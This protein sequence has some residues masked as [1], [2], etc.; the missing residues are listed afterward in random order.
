M[1]AAVLV[2]QAVLQNLA[3]IILVVVSLT[4]SLAHNTL[5]QESTELNDENDQPSLYLSF[6]LFLQVVLLRLPVGL[7][8]LPIGLL[9][10]PAGSGNL[11]D[12]TISLTMVTQCTTQ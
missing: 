4:Q 10:L 2:F 11:F 3:G 1:H 8:R 7:L 5:R 12:Q 9:R 6:E